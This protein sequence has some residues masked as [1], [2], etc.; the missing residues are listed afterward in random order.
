MKILYV[1]TI[2]NTINAFMIPH[3]EL[4]LNQGHKVDIACNINKEISIYLTERGCKVYDMEFQRSIFTKYNL[5]AYK[6]LNQLIQKENYDIVHT[7]T[8]VASAFVR[9][10]CKSR[11][12]VK[13]MYTAHGFHFYTG[14][15]FK[16]WLLYYPVERYL[17][18]YTD[19]II[20][21]NKEDYL[22]A[23]NSFK[24]GRVEYIPGVGLDIKK[25]QSQVVD[26]ISKRKEINLPE[27]ACIVLS[28]GELNKNKNHETIIKAISKLKGQ[29]LYYVICGQGQN[30]SYL[31]ELT[32]ELGIEKQV[33]FLGYR[34]D[35]YEIL[36]V[37]DIFAFPSFREGLPVALMEAMACGLPIV[38][39]EIRGNMDLIENDKGGVLVR[40]D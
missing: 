20:T 4:L 29:N 37:T 16:N 14:A 21:L 27:D 31:R 11:E 22:R 18:K 33:R 5:S 23:K 13:V 40:P 35:I 2:S 38:C 19:Y 12:N 7:H 15:P 10:A 1:S 36:K 25:I 34:S 3:I 26:K 30:E 24:A 9:L 8:P 6:K 32:K 28:V 39:S 17:S